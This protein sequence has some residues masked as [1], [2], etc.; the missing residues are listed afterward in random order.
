MSETD[1]PF[2]TGRLVE[3]LAGKASAILRADI[4]RIVGMA[5]GDRVDIVPTTAG[6]LIRKSPQPVPRDAA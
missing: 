3:G 1:K 2:D 6:I 5:P 4:L